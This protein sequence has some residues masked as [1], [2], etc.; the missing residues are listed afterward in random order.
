[1]T[2]KPIHILMAD[3]DLED[4]ELME[5][6]II[7]IEPTVKF[8]K[9]VNGKAVIDYLGKRSEDDLPCLIILDYNMPELTGSQVLSIICKDKRYEAIP[10]IIL[11][12]SSTHAYINE[13]MKNG[14]TEYLVK[15]DNMAALTAMAKKLLNY[16]NK[17]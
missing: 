16:C 12:T 13:C 5:T 11:S 2:D 9:V 6:A 1:M 10:K 14:A 8:Q 15:P 3:D 17:N 7:T 4:I